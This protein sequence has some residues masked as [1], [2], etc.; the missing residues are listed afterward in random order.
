MNEAD[1]ERCWAGLRPASGDGLPYIGVLPGVANAFIAAGHYR[2]GLIQAPGTAVVV[3][4]L[5]QGEATAI[6]L[7]PFRPGREAVYVH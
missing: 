6:D 5:M 2:S 4:Q 3:S 1:V 7:D